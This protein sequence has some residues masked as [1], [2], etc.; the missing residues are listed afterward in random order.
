MTIETKYAIGQVVFIDGLDWHRAW[1]DG[2]KISGKN[3][4]YEVAYWWNGE[5]KTVQLR[6]EDISSENHAKDKTVRP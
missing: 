5:L 2:I 3:T 6:E 1:I 4:W